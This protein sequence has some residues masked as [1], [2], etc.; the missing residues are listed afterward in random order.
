[1]APVVVDPDRVKEFADFDAFYAWLKA[2]HDSA[3][4]VWIRIFKKASGRATITPAEAIDAVLCWG[5]IDAI[6]K[7]WDDVSFVQR[8]CPRR[9]KSVWSQINRD[10]VARM[11]AA[12]KMTGHGLAQVEKA[13]ADGR[14]DAAYK[15]SMEPPAD[16][17]AAIAASPKAQAAYET[18]SAQNR[19]ALTFRTHNM[20]TPAG[21]AK[22]IADSVAMLE[23]GETI[24]PQKAKP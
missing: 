5:W 19:F 16:L 1:M 13:K 11:I 17:L 15:Q 6:R 12:G 7:S 21:R 8:Y 23:R 14:W 22:K 2:N 10:N 24:H 3:E 20:K 18:L 9:G 4:E